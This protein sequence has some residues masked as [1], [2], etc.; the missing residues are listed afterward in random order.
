MEAGKLNRESVCVRG[1]KAKITST[2]TVDDV[3]LLEQFSQLQWAWLD[4]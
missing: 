2:M 3:M 1:N 4:H